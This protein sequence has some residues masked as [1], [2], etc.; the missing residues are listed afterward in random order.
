MIVIHYSRNFQNLDYFNT[1]ESLKWRSVCE[2][3]ILWR[4]RIFSSY[5]IKLIDVTYMYQRISPRYSSQLRCRRVGSSIVVPAAAAFP[6]PFRSIRAG[7]PFV[8]RAKNSAVWE[9]WGPVRGR[10]GTVRQ[11][12]IPSCDIGHAAVAVPAQPLAERVP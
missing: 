7:R 9:P 6:R 4:W 8:E 3:I 2:C 5:I 10:Y 12:V 1:P 11:P